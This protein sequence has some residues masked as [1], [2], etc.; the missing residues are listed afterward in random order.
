LPLH[1]LRQLLPDRAPLQLHWHRKAGWLGTHLVP[2]LPNAPSKRKIE[3]L[4]HRTHRAGKQPL[5]TAYGEPGGTRM[6]NEVR[7]ASRLGDLFAWLVM[8]RRPGA[9]IEFG[10]AFGV[11]G[12]YFMAGLAATNNGHLYSFE[13]NDQ[14]ADI[15]EANILA[16]GERVVLTRGTFEEHVDRVVPGPIDLAFVDGIHSYEFVTR[17]FGILLPRMRPGGVLIF[18]DINFPREGARMHEAW[19]E[20]VAD[21]AVIAA[22]E[23][24]RQLG[25]VEIAST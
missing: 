21:S 13:I 14:W 22:V 8:Q 3:R 9:V 11:S 4:A 17:Q 7:S 15:A 25:V 6:P 12:M 20:I 16:L 18:D 10:S 5:A 2:D 19:Q 23:V 1:L 24:N